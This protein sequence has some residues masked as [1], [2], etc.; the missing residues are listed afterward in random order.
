MVA[1]SP[2]PLRP[3]GSVW[4][5]YLPLVAIVVAVGIVAVVVSSGGD[6]D[7]GNAT[8]T[9]A[10]DGIE[11]PITYAQAVDDGTVDDYDWGP[12]CDTD[13]GD[14]AM[15]DLTTPPCVPAFTGDNGGA[16]HRGV[17]AET[18]KIAYYEPKPDPQTDALL[19]ISGAYDA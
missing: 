6:D 15:Y 11:L 12:N 7:G 3:P 5:R 4:R 19:Q 13:A 10:A 9:T 1:N 17:T 18:I 14:I 2:T 8:D 16:T